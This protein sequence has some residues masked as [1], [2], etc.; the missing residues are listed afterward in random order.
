MSRLSARVPRGQC[1]VVSM[2]AALWI[3]LALGAFCVVPR[4]MAITPAEQETLLKLDGSAGPNWPHRQAVALANKL[5]GEGDLSAVDFLLNQNRRELAGSLVSAYFSRGV[6][7]NMND[8]AT[9]FLAHRS[10]P[11][12]KW[13]LLDRWA[14]RPD[15]S[16][17][18]AALFDVLLVDL[19][20]GDPYPGLTYRVAQVILSTDVPN[21][22]ERV[23]DALSRLP[24]P[25]EAPLVKPAAPPAAGASHST[26]GTLGG[27]R[28]PLP[29]EV[30]LARPSVPLAAGVSLPM[31]GIQGW[32]RL[33]KR[34]ADRQYLAAIPAMRAWLSDRPAGDQFAAV[35]DDALITFNR[36]EAIA[37]LRERIG[38]LSAVPNGTDARSEFEA[39]GFAF[40]RIAREIPTPYAQ[41]S[42]LVPPTLRGSSDGPWP[43]LLRREAFAP[44]A[45]ALIRKIVAHY[46]GLE[47]YADSGTIESSA[48]QL[49]GDFESRFTRR[50]RYVST[51]SLADGETQIDWGYPGC[52]NWYRSFPGGSSTHDCVPGPFSPPNEVNSPALSVLTEGAEY[53]YK[54]SYIYVVEAVEGD[55]KARV[56]LKGTR[57]H[58][59]EL[60]RAYV[61]D[62]VTGSI[63]SA[64]I[65]DGWRLKYELQGRDN[66]YIPIWEWW[67]WRGVLGQF[68][69]LRLTP[70]GMV[71]GLLAGILLGTSMQLIGLRRWLTP[72][73]AMDLQ[74]SLRRYRRRLAV[75]LGIALVLLGVAIAVFLFLLPRLLFVAMLLGY[76]LLAWGIVLLKVAVGFFL[77]SLA[78]VSARIGRSGK[79]AI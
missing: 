36:P 78:I 50:G 32:S 54:T 60:Y 18:S 12:I 75:W 70:R 57:P 7:P 77:G 44:A 3:I 68:V 19:Q 26:H 42:D 11:Q 33:T 25:P 16:Y 38:F 73:T 43:E 9:L 40:T 6:P 30:L 20:N 34:F 10:D 35:I 14:T 31:L 46:Q 13:V 61:V 41:V 27:L 23:L 65:F 79:P 15:A 17:S 37:V 59:P 39:I 45:H 29:P 48:M 53:F 72:G 4:A 55:P 58:Y 49:S 74:G 76:F 24:Q 63:A 52:A 22:D 67:P 21:A 51:L 8:F 71:G 69:T 28:L 56:R 1:D 47:T 5:G 64:E 2:P 62:P 66:P